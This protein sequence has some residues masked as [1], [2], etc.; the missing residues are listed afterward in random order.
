MLGLMGSGDDSM[1]TQFSDG[2]G[3][4]LQNMTTDET[5]EWLYKLF[6]RERPIVEE[7]VTE[8]FLPTVIYEPEEKETK[9]PVIIIAAIVIAVAVILVIKKKKKAGLTEEDDFETEEEKD[10][11]EV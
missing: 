5:V 1:M 7:K 3:A 11:Q 2:M 6:F 8:K 4:E 9:T 10:F